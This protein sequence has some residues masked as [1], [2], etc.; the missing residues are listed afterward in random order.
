MK[1]KHLAGL[2]A[3]ALITGLSGCGRK[4]H[5][6][7]G[8]LVWQDGQPA[9]E[10]AG[11]MVYFESTEHHTVSR[12]AVNEEGQFLLTTDRPEARGPDG[13]PPGVHRVYVIDGIPPRVDP[14]FRKPDTSGLEVT[15]PP[16]GPVVL[17]L[18]RARGQVLGPRPRNMPP[19]P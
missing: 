7:E 10:L 9:K 3:L 6:V 13:V 1:R 5:P 15:V 17:K 18:E 2:A 11:S 19:V 8:Q 16:E 14:R 12:S 4:L